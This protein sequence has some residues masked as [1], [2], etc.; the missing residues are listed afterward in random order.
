[1][2]VASKMKGGV[3]TASA[4]VAQSLNTAGQRTSSTVTKV[5]RDGGGKC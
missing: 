5:F 3:R 4:K 1:M 2:N